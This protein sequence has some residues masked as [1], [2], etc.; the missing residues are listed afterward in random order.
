MKKSY[1][2]PIPFNSQLTQ[3]PT[4]HRLIQERGHLAKV[5]PEDLSK[6]GITL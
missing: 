3:I 4:I 5:E 6:L 1:N 2:G